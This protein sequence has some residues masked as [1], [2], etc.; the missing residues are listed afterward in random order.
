MTPPSKGRPVAID[1][2]KPI[3]AMASDPSTGGYWL[4]AADGGIFSFDAPFLGS[5]G[6]LNLTRPIVGATS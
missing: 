4:V 5:T 3:V 6:N 2:N 1:L